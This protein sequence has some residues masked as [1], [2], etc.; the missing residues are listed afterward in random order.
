M[1][2]RPHRDHFAFRSVE[3][4][5]SEYAG[6]NHPIAQHRLPFSFNVERTTPPRK[7]QGGRQLEQPSRTPPEPEKPNIR[8]RIDDPPQVYPS[9]KPA[10]DLLG[11][12]Q[13]DQRGEPKPFISSHPP[14]PKLL[15]N[16]GP[17]P[18]PPN[19]Q[20]A[21]PPSRRSTGI[22]TNAEVYPPGRGG[23]GQAAFGERP[24]APGPDEA[25]DSGHGQPGS[26]TGAPVAKAPT[27][28][29]K[30]RSGGGSGQIAPSS[31]KAAIR[32]AS[33]ITTHTT[34]LDEAKDSKHAESGSTTGAPGSKASNDISVIPPITNDKGGSRGRSNQVPLGVIDT[35]LGPERLIS[36]TPPANPVSSGVDKMVR[37]AATAFRGVIPHPSGSGTSIAVSR[38]KGVTPHPGDENP[39]NTSTTAIE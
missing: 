28:S 3:A 5:L 10:I 35:S 8:P 27:N 25:N 32:L 12:L 30:G 7:T 31:N 20:A 19:A 9:T 17:N 11:S 6:Q 36:S 24:S 18:T 37:Q 14:P 4:I 38:G 22:K 29:D 33:D 15:Q 16:A 1:L 39:S 2:S 23:S 26:N 21:A 34:N 13:G